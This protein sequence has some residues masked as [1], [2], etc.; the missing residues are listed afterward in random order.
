MAFRQRVAAD[1]VASQTA[2]FLL[3]RLHRTY[4]AIWAESVRGV[5]TEREFDA[6][7]EI[8]LLGE[9][10]APMN[11]AARFRLPDPG[12]TSD[13]RTVLYSRDR[14][15]CASSVDQVLGLIDIRRE[16]ILPLPRLFSGEE[17]TWFR[18]LILFQ[19]SV[20]LL[21]N[22]DWLVQEDQSDRRLGNA[23]GS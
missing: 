8:V 15:G 1:T 9:R 10:Y 17:R 13:T 4:L 16:H 12:R 21:I 20:A 22:P 5:F 2:R 7:Q 6:R 23:I 11:L 18:G 19:D 14:W 3:V